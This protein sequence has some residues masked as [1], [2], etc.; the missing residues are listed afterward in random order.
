MHTF[1]ST[2]GLQVPALTNALIGVCADVVCIFADLQ[3]EYVISLGNSALKPPATASTSA[4]AS[5]SASTSASAAS[6]SSASSAASVCA[7]MNN[8]ERI[9]EMLLETLGGHID[10]GPE[11]DDEADDEL[12]EDGREGGGRF[13]AQPLAVG[14]EAARKALLRSE[15]QLNAI[16]PAA[17]HTLVAICLYQP[18]QDTRGQPQRAA[19]VARELLPL[20]P[21]SALN[22]TLRLGVT[23]LHWVESKVVESAR[24]RL[25]R[26]M[27]QLL[28]GHCLEA[29]LAGKSAFLAPDGASGGAAVL[30]ALDQLARQALQGLNEKVRD[31]EL[32]PLRMLLDV[33]GS[34]LQSFPQRFRG[35]RQAHAEVGSAVAEALLAKRG[36]PKAEV[37]EIA[38]QCVPPGEPLPTKRRSSLI[39]LSTFGGWTP[40]QLSALTGSPFGLATSRLSSGGSNWL[41]ASSKLGAFGRMAAHSRG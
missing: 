1:A 30:Q 2:A 38:A 11:D 25:E 16:T 32:L 9:C 13:A 33:G 20:E 10:E 6:S 5:A 29:L 8:A 17:T 7:V 27:V 3:R 22:E 4:S 31:K 37:K 39:P 18:W 41:K 28:V 26:G 19:H 40:T 35:L 14:D 15:E 36:L 12:D 34:D 21:F 23:A 24:T